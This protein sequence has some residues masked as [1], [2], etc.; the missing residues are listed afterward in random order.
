MTYVMTGKNAWELTFSHSLAVDQ[1]IKMMPA[2][3]QL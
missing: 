3:P 2:I 1:E